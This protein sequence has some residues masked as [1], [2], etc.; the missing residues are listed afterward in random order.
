MKIDVTLR[1]TNKRDWWVCCVVTTFARVIVI[2]N[3]P[4]VCLSVGASR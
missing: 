3:A 1:R 2:V 4:S